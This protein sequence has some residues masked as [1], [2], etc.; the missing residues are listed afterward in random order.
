MI[1]P[2]REQARRRSLFPRF[3]GEGAPFDG[4]S[5]VVSRHTRMLGER[6]PPPSP[7]R[8]LVVSRRKS[9]SIWTAFFIGVLPHRFRFNAG[10]IPA[11]AIVLLAVGTGIA[12]SWLN[13][14]LGLLVRDP[15]SAGLAGLFPVIALVV[16]S[17]TLVPVASMP[18]WLQAFPKVNPITVVV[19]ALR[20]L[21]LGGPIWTPVTHAFAWIGGLLVL[22]VPAAIVVYGRTTS[23]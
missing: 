12:F 1:Q 17:S 16:T 21:C 7:E 22:T 20:A 13:L 5:Y 6:A 3:D 8:H 19:D 11:L 14:L 2:T 15:E 18:G 4:S 23:E 9:C 10:S